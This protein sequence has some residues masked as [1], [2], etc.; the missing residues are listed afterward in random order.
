MEG[1][2]IMKN[3]LNVL[4]KELYIDNNVL[5]HLVRVETACSFSVSS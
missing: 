3:I 5:I 1:H 2:L 4:E